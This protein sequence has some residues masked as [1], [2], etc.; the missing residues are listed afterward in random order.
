M[1]V[2]GLCKKNE[3]NMAKYKLATINIGRGNRLDFYGD[4]YTNFVNY[5]LLFVTHRV[6]STCTSNECPEKDVTSQDGLI[7]SIERQDEFVEIIRQ[8][9]FECWTAPCGKAFK[10]PIEDG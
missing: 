7:P 5:M 9:L 3:Y 4:E 2:L 8:W 1:A 10:Q 6:T